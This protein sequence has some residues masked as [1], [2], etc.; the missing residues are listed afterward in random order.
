MLSYLLG[1]LNQWKS[2]GQG[3]H[4]QRPAPVVGC[5]PRTCLGFLKD[6]RSYKAV[7]PS[8]VKYLPTL[9]LMKP[10]QPGRLLAKEND[11]VRLSYRL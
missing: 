8:G 11:L 1:K 4:I 2:C 6:S 5:L 7:M 3:Y 10:A 9:A